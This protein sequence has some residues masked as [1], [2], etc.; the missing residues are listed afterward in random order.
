[1]TTI[2]RITLRSN[3]TETSMPGR[4]ESHFGGMAE[5]VSHV[6]KAFADCQ[7]VVFEV[8]GFGQ[9]K[10]PVDVATDL[11][12]VVEQLPSVLARLRR[13][14]PAVELDF[15]EQ[16][17]ER[18]VCFESRADDGLTVSCLSSSAHWQPNPAEYSCPRSEIISMLSGVLDC[19]AMWTRVIFPKVDEYPPF[20]EWVCGE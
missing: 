8:Q 17:V 19:F 9:E 13:G 2:F 20:A 14:D 7:A 3:L 11:S 4:S 10:W 12:V 15:Y 5:L 6:C 18:V 1:M 16:G